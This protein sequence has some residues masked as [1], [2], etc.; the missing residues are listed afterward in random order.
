MKNQYKELIHNIKLNLINSLN[1]AGNEISDDG[2]KAIAE[3]LKEN[4]S[5][6]NLDLR[7]TKIGD[8]GAKAIAEAL[9][10][11]TSVTN[12]DLSSNKI[13]DEGAKAIAEALTVNTT[14][15]R[16]DIHKN[17]IGAAGAKDIVDFI[18]RNVDLLQESAKEAL[19]NIEDTDKVLNIND[20]VR[21]TNCDKHLLKI[22]IT[23][24][25][26]NQ[27]ITT[28]LK[29]NY[30]KENALQIIGV[31]NK[32]CS[33]SE[34]QEARHISDL[35]PEVTSLIMSFLSPSDCIVS[36]I[37]PDMQEVPMAGN[38]EM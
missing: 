33:T 8:D 37:N 1:L 26:A 21:L 14:I 20:L 19:N 15:T 18:R 2:V 25:G 29:P 36:E 6:T 9:K 16:L 7:Y 23:E 12:L 4:T 17:Q 27:L 35:P 11:N 22:L 38:A 10:K 5:V 24:E 3:A 13:S 34:P 28:Y 30:F 32:E 31:Y